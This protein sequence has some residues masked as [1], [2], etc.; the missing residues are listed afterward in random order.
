VVIVGVDL[1]ICKLFV[2]FFLVVM[3][4]MSTNATVVVLIL[5]SNP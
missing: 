2:D 4:L 5:L 1:L 3:G